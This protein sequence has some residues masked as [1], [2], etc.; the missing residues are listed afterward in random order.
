M[1][2]IYRIGQCLLLLLAFGFTAC[3]NEIEQPIQWTRLA[4]FPGTPRASANAFSIGHKAYVCFGRSGPSTGLLKDVWEYD[5]ITD[6]WTQKADF[7]GKR[8]SRP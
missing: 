5:A 7:P 4:D 2:S 8:A 3:D 1:L 6:T